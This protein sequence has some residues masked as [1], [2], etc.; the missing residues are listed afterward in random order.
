MS[1]I[2]NVDGILPNRPYKELKVL[3]A[4]YEGAHAVVDELSVLNA[5][6]DFEELDTRNIPIFPIPDRKLGQI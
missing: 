5:V 1:N 2:G 6:S 4:K 3:V